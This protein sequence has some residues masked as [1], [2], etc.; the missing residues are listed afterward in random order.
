MP[1]SASVPSTFVAGTTIL[2]SAANAN[3][4]A[5][6]T[7]LNTTGVGFYQAGTVDQTALAALSV[8][9]AKLALG[10][11]AN[12]NLAANAAVLAP[13]LFAAIPAAASVPAGTLY[14]ATDVG[15]GALYRSDGSSWAAVARMDAV[16][17]AANT[18]TSAMLQAASVTPTKLAV[19]AVAIVRTPSTAV[20]SGDGNKVVTGAGTAT[21]ETV[22]SILDVDATTSRITIG[23]TGLYNVGIVET[24]I[25]TTLAAGASLSWIVAK[26]GA[27]VGP[28]AYAYNSLGVAGNAPTLPNVSRI[29][30]LTAGDYLQLIIANNSAT[31]ATMRAYLSATYLGPAA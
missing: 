30:S 10:S 22:P 20:V 26:N 16:A 17:P 9:N 4:Q 21:L 23:A 28:T 31:S 3:F 8:T 18:I 2:A 13:G 14:P 12:N 24:E 29:L 11:V 15:V 6:L 19:P 7:Y 1:T 5:L 27:S 25:S